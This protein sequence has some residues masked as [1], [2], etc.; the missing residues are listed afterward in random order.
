[1]L[2]LSHSAANWEYFWARFRSPNWP[3]LAALSTMCATMVAV[4]KARNSNNKPVGISRA[5][6]QAHARGNPVQ[7]VPSQ[8]PTGPSFPLSDRL[9]LRMRQNPVLV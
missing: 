2:E 9:R 3:A 6:F 4:I 5:V 1:L 8:A 7:I